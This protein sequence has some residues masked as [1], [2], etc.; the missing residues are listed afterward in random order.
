MP[1]GLLCGLGKSFIF[2]IAIFYMV[3]VRPLRVGILRLDFDIVARFVCH[4][5]ENAIE[6]IVSSDV[7]DIPF[8]SMVSNTSNSG[9]YGSLL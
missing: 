3:V 6:K 5:V 9:I 7:D 8:A 2:A 4:R 1:S